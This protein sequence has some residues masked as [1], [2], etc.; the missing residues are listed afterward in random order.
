MIELQ[1][2]EEFSQKCKEVKSLFIGIFED[3]S[4]DIY[5]SSLSNSRIFIRNFIKNRKQ[6]K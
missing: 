3:V 4:M 5:R 1:K 6:G 2:F